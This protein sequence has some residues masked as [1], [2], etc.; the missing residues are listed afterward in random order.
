MRAQTRTTSC[1]E[2][3]NYIARYGFEIKRVIDN[4]NYCLIDFVDPILEEEVSGEAPPAY[5][6]SSVYLDK[7]TGKVETT[8]RIRVKDIK[9]V[10]L[11]N[12]DY[13][14]RPHVNMELKTFSLE[15]RYYNRN[16][17]EKFKDLLNYLH[18]SR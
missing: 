9:E 12:E 1:Q 15:A 2:L 16:A 14:F 7:K 18:P 10:E 4:P 13:Y 6:T 3:A 8:I 11:T 5:Y 17:I